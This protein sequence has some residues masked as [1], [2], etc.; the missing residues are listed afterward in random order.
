MTRKPF[1]IYFI[2]FI[3]LPI[4]PSICAGVEGAGQPARLHQDPAD[5]PQPCQQAGGDGGDRTFK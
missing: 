3:Y 5:S 4:R 1:I 2:I